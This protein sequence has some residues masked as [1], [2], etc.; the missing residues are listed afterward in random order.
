MTKESCSCLVRRHFLARSA[1]LLGGIGIAALPHRAEANHAATAPDPQPRDAIPA[2]L[3][4][5]TRYP[6]VGISEAH[7]MQEQHDFFV[8]LLQHPALPGR[9]NDIV[10]EFGNARYQATADRFLLDLQPVSNAA[11]RLIWRNTV[12]SGGNP[13]WDAPVYEQ[14]FRTVRAVNW[15][16]PVAHRLRVVLGDPPID[17]N[18]VRG[19]ADI[20]AALPFVLARDA[21]YARVVEHDVLAK[22]RRALLIAGGGHLWRGVLADNNVP[23]QPNPLNA[24]TLLSRRYPGKLF[25]IDVAIPPP[26]STDQ[27]DRLVITWPRPRIATIAGTWVAT[28]P[29]PASN[30][31]VAT[32]YGAMVDA[33][34]YL[35]AG[36]QL[37]ASRA[38]PS[39]YEGGSYAAE[40]ERRGKLFVLAGAQKGNALVS[41]LHVATLGPSYFA[42]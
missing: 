33:L 31:N 28:I 21:H 34:L 30:R 14:F 22:G 5:L 9:I 26:G 36:S 20:P 4:A 16:L 18:T 8:A 13:V 3:D 11:L 1:T 19:A 6:L 42:S 10:V 39:L 25:V 27:Q 40:L 41:A 23:G 7:Q 32:T 24:G 2:V 37:T 12:I 35:G 17:W 38:D 15:A 29:I